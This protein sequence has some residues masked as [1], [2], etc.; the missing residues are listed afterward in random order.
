MTSDI[1]FIATALHFYVIYR[2]FSDE[3]IEIM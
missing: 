3:H 1:I 2:S